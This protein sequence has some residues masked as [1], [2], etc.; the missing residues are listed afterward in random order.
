MLLKFSANPRKKNIRGESSLS[1]ACMQENYEIC[2]RLIL[3][4][5]DVN[6]IDN[7]KRTPLLKAARHNS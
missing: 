6:E 1:L 4:K 7:R 2:E 3:A 5:A